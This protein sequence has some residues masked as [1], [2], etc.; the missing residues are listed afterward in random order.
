MKI[1][2]TWQDWFRRLLLVGQTIFK[3]MTILKN[4]RFPKEMLKV[5]IIA[6]GHSWRFK[7]DPRINLVSTPPNYLLKI[8]SFSCRSL[9]QGSRWI[10][11]KINSRWMTTVVQ[12]QQFLHQTKQCKFNSYQQI[13]H[14]QILTLV[15]SRNKN[16]RKPHHSP[17]IQCSL[18]QTKVN[19]CILLP[20]IMWYLQRVCWCK[21]TDRTCL[22][23]NKSTKVY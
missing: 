10:W 2:S 18:P 9:I 5:A 15:I 11:E 12:T 19:F 13:L 3:W 7:L 23:L 1:I 22:Y 14:E 16:L 21:T 8:S 4:S 17:H 6:R 20:K